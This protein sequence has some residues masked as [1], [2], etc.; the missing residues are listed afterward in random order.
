MSKPTIALRKATTEDLKFVHS[1]WVTNYGHVWGYKNMPISLFKAEMDAYVDRRTANDTVL[2]A[3]FPDVP[4]EI[5]GWA[6]FSG[7]TLHY[8]YVKG[9]YRRSGIATG[10]VG[11]GFIKWYTPHAD[12][13]AKKFAKSINAQFNPFRGLK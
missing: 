13:T 2:I 8:V 11:G 1:S 9:V 5:L 10:L 4:D 12:A 7:D 6:C 3:Y